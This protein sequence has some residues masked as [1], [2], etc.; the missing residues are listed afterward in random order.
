MQN[1]NSDR[2]TAAKHLSKREQCS[3]KAVVHKINTELL[4][5]LPAD[6]NELRNVVPSTS[7]SQLD[8]INYNGD[9]CEVVG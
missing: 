5:Q 4:R 3:I 2:T 9:N 7:A 8:H 6:S 1:A